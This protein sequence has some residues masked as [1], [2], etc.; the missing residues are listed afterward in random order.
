[1]SPEIKA[2]TEKKI[3]ELMSRYPKKQAAILPVLHL[4]QREL[5]YISEDGEKWVADLLGI[6]PVKV[7]E[8]VTFYSM[9]SRKPLGKY[10]IQICSNLTCSL[11]GAESLIDYV[12]EKLGIKPGETSEDGK[13]TLTTVECLGACDQAPSMMINTDYYGNMDKKKIDK[14]LKEL[15]K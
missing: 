9:L 11:M 7:R 14:I 12:S 10:H 4:V 1:M 2:S 15:D 6:N 5:G 13:F 8:V 3:K